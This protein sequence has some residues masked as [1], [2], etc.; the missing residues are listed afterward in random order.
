MRRTRAA[1]IVKPESDEQK[2]NRETVEGIAQNIS[3]LARAVTALLGGPLKKRTIIVLL[4]ASTGLS[5]ATVEAV[6]TALE[7]LE[8]D[9]LAR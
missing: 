9:W 5:K 1:Q 4:A 6:L 8:K 3:S 2:R 7:S